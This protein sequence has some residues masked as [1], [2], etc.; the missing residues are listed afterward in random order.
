VDWDGIFQGLKKHK[1][2]GHLAIDVGIV[3][4]IDARYRE[5]LEFLQ[6]KAAQ[7]GLYDGP[8]APGGTCS[9]EIGSPAAC[10]SPAVR[11]SLPVATAAW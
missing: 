9:D 5:S 3:P 8:V 1:F 4:D 7:Y 6:A 11:C 2:S 10:Q